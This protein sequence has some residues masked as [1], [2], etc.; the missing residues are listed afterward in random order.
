MGNHLFVIFAVLDVSLA[1]NSC[2]NQFFLHLYSIQSANSVVRL[3]YC[4]TKMSMST[5]RKSV[6]GVDYLAL[7]AKSNDDSEC[8][9]LSSDE[10]SSDSEETDSDSDLLDDVHVWCSIDTDQPSTAAPRFPFTGQ[11]GLQVPV[12]DNNDT[13]TYLRLF[14]DDDIM[15]VIV[16]ETN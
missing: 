7:D 10:F 3:C 5:K 4:V 12:A 13:L 2:I 9:N 11:P 14:L 8:E 15:D 16:T 6:N 1:I